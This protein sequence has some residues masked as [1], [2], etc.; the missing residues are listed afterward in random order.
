MD[1]D[2]ARATEIQLN[3]EDTRAEPGA[4]RAQGRPRSGTRARREQAQALCSGELLHR[5]MLFLLLAAVNA[6][7]QPENSARALLLISID[8]LRPDYVLEADKHGLKIPQLRALARDGAHA[9]TVRG[10]LPTATY[11]SHTTIITGVSPARHGIV[12]NHPF[13]GA[14]KGID[15]WYYYAEDLHAPTLWDAATAA[16]YT[17]GNVSWPVTVGATSIRFNIPEFNLTRTDED[18]KLTRGAATPGLMAELSV[19]AGTYI[20]DNTKAVERDGARTRYALEL[21]RLKHPRFLTVHLVATDHLQHRDGPFTPKV[22]AA[23]EEIDQ[24]VGQL[25][26]A[27]RAED[28]GAAVC[29]VSDHGFAPVN[30]VF[31]LDT[32]FVKAGLITL[33]G[34][35]KTVEEA[36]IKQW[37]ARPW[38]ASGSAAIVLKQPQDA[39]ARTKVKGVL[40]SLAADPANGIAAVLDE[41]AIRN[42][43]G[44]PTAQFWIDMRPGFSISPSLA[45]SIVS[46]VS[47]RGT[48]GYAPTHPEMG[49]T[50]IIAGK[51]IRGGADLG[52]IDMRSIAPTLA[53]LMGVPFPSAEMPAQDIFAESASR[54]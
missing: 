37:I 22:H 48:H 50:F 49:S 28:P 53:K 47:A 35:G 23:L 16:G 5:L 13:E 4:E 44:A 30:H 24:M 51:G 36:G 54:R 26:D 42:L 46:A 7:A 43:G 32:A 12:A 52:S 34:Q 33:Q 20:T 27:M 14:V 41:V 11:P 21:L 15:V 29:I 18:V 9:R 31:Y 2:A 45:P 40:D 19:R 39:G 6:F 25:A 3:M 38:S 1:D 17:V 8:G 10:V